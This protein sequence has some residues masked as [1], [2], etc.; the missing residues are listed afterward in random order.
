MPS[1]GFN[2]LK[3]RSCGRVQ[4]LSKIRWARYA[5]VMELL[6]FQKIHLCSPFR[7]TFAMAAVD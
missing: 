3:L 2:A 4:R 1:F 7:V 5:G 6:I